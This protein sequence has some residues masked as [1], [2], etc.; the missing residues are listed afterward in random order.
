MLRVLLCKLAW[1]VVQKLHCYLLLLPDVFFRSPSIHQQDEPQE[2]RQ[3]LL[4]QFQAFI[5]PP[6]TTPAQP[7]HSSVQLGKYACHLH[8]E[9]TSSHL[10][11]EVG[12]PRLSAIR[13]PETVTSAP[14]PPLPHIVSIHRS[15]SIT[16]SFAVELRR[17]IA[18]ETGNA[19]EKSP[20]RSFAARGCWE[21]NWCLRKL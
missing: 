8:H 19:R 15:I 7:T 6:L 12:P 11:L 1:F 17:V 2:L 18:C 9:H 20:P 5:L 10:I 16:K 21:E 3:R 4:L 13:F 14:L